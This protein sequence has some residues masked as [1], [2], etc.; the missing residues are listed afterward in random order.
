M[1]RA[2][3]SGY[4]KDPTG[5]DT[6]FHKDFCTNANADYALLQGRDPFSSLKMLPTTRSRGTTYVRVSNFIFFIS[7]LTVNNFADLDQYK[8]TI[9]NTKS[10]TARTYLF[11]KPDELHHVHAN[12]VLLV[13]KSLLTCVNADTAAL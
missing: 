7:T 10:T 8:K 4:E 12:E 11:H 2:G 9:R 5:G 6:Y 1:Q 3:K 13:A